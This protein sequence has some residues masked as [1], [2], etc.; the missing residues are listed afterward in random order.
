MSHLA[1]QHGAPRETVQLARAADE[2][3]RGRAPAHARAAYF[4][5]EA[6]GHAALRDNRATELALG[7]A[8]DELDRVPAGNGVP[9]WAAYFDHYY[10]AD[11]A[12]HCYRDL[13]QPRQAAEHAVT[14][15]SGF[16]VEKTRRRVIDLF[17]LASAR[18]QAG[19]V[20]AGCAT[21]IDAVKLS[22]RARSARSVEALHDFER[23]L[24]QHG[25]VAAVR[26]FRAFVA[27]RRP[28]EPINA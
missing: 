5:A 24:D 21:A 4:C 2:G 18:I 7:R 17:V 13:G 22:A 15:L 23:R 20:E 28:G 1:A 8:T 25:A 11:S 16:P 26:E 10:L 27:L 3:S 19:E 9:T 6:R 12:A 14:A